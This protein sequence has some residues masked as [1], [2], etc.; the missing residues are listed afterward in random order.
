MCSARDVDQDVD[1]VRVVAAHGIDDRGVGVVERFG[2]AMA[3]QAFG[4]RQAGVG[5]HQR[6]RVDPELRHKRTDA[7]AR[8]NDEHRLAD[9]GCSRST[10]SNPAITLRQG[11]GGSMCTWLSSAVVVAAQVS[12][13]GPR[14]RQGRGGVGTV[15]KASGEGVDDEPPRHHGWSARA[16]SGSRSGATD[17]PWPGS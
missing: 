2:C 15:G 4:V 10:M 7:A 3:A 9:S 17:G 6:A 1:A 8:T 16:G 11:S 5:D 13:S 14:A 12:I